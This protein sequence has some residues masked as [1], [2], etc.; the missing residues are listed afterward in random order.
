MAVCEV[1]EDAPRPVSFTPK[2]ASQR[3]LGGARGHV[4]RHEVA[5]GRIA[6]LQI[7]VAVLLGDVAKA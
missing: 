6:A 2:P 1:E 4:A 3:F 7:V 5:E